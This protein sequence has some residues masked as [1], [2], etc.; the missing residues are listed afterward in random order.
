MAGRDASANL[1][2]MLSQIGGAFGAAGQSVGQG[3][4]RPITMAFRP[5]VVMTDPESL[6][7]QA[8]FYGRVGDTEQQR[9]F[10]T[11]AET[12]AEKQQAEAQRTGQ[13]AIAGIKQEIMGVLQ[14]KVLTPEQKSAKLSELQTK[15]DN[16][17]ATYKLNPLQTADLATTTQRDYLSGVAANN[18]VL[19][20]QT[21]IETEA[22][23]G[24]G[25]AKIA[26]L[27]ANIQETLRNP[28]LSDEERQN[29]LTAL[30]AEVTE[31]ATKH[32]LNPT[33]YMG[34][35]NALRTGYLAEQSNELNLQSAKNTNE[36]TLALRVLEGAFE[37][38]NQD[39][40]AYQAA[41]ANIQ[42]KHPGLLK[43]FDRAE[44]RYAADKAAWERAAA[45]TGDFTEEEKTYYTDVLG[46]PESIVNANNKAGLHKA[47][48]S[49][50]VTESIRQAAERRKTTRGDAI[51]Y[52]VIQDVLP[53]VL[54]EIRARKGSGAGIF[55]DTG[56]ADF[57]DAIDDNPEALEQ[58]AARVKADGATN[59]AEV[60]RAVLL[61]LER[62]EPGALADLIANNPDFAAMFEVPAAKK[63]DD[64]KDDDDKQDGTTTVTLPN[65]QTATIKQKSS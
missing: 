10:S 9:M 23:Q 64:K 26:S 47:F 53:S 43:Q 1:G 3:L 42:Q 40:N 29:K 44:E 5:Q 16:T 17:A 59:I 41:R 52:G 58:F 19:D 60:K 65:G 28:A 27:N 36:R 48:R 54:Q 57:I 30:Q 20:R 13:A 25:R 45:N 12:V 39:P 18:A 4:M 50:M 46:I 61:E 7:K 14:S 33:Q 35:V 32:K 63:D 49:Q 51:A 8:A 22:T 55:W 21:A 56:A 11:Q 6:R 62:N 34:L 2:G 15:A 31:T 24:E 37:N 38:K